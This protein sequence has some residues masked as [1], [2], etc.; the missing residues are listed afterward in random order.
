MRVARLATQQAPQLQLLSTLQ[1]QL[2]LLQPCVAAP[3]TRILRARNLRAH[4]PLSSWQFSSP[5]SSG[6]R[7]LRSSCS[8][9]SG[10]RTQCFTLP[11][12]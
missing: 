1:S 9:S 3:S 4:S 12:A 8:S 7:K 5:R 11:Q 2:T 6:P 10:R